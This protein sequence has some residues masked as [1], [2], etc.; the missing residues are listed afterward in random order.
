MPF[1]LEWSI[2]FALMALKTKKRSLWL[3]VW[4]YR[5]HSKR[6]ISGAHTTNTAPCKTKWN[7]MNY[8]A[9]KRCNKMCTTLFEA[10]HN[11]IGKNTRNSCFWDRCRLPRGPMSRCVRFSDHRRQKSF[12]KHWKFS[13]I[14]TIKTRNGKQD[15]SAII[16]GREQALLAPA[17]IWPWWDPQPRLTYGAHFP[18]KQEQKTITELI[19]SGE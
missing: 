18:L 2:L 1:H 7:P 5:L 17:S 15:V 3:V 9:R 4:K 19:F 14:L 11:L 8:Y 12:H 13:N 16:T 10:I 6:V